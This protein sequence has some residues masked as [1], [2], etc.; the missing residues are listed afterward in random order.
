MDKQFVAKIFL[1]FSFL[2]ISAVILMQIEAVIEKRTQYRSIAQKSVATSWSGQQKI[3][4]PILVIPYTTDIV[5]D[6]G[7]KSGQLYFLAEQLKVKSALNTQNKH[8]GVFEFPVY[9]T[10]LDFEGVFSL[11]DVPHDMISD[12]SVRFETPY[13][14]FAVTDMRGINNAPS[15]KLADKTFNFYPR[16]KLRFSPQGIHAPL[17][18]Y[19]GFSFSQ[20]TKF[21]FQ[22][23][24]SL[25]GMNG[26]SVIPLA[27]Q[28]NLNMKS[29]WAHPNF[30]GNFL[31]SDHKIDK[32]KFTANWQVS[33]FSSNIYQYL[34]EC[35]YGSCSNLLNTRIDV[36]LNTPVDI[37]RQSIRSIKYGLMF[38]GITLLCFLLFE[39]VKKWQ[40]HAMQY[41]LLSM[42]ISVF[43]LLLVALSEHMSFVWAYISASGACILLLMGYLVSILK[44]FRLAGLFGS[45]IALLYGFMFAVLSSEDSALLLGSLL[46]FVLLAIVMI[47]TR[48]TN[49]YELAEKSKLN[50]K[51]KDISQENLK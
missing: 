25:R 8:K 44:S 13:V 40:I 31:P 49:W 14:S 3:T 23:N 17:D 32:K 6:K 22:F 42:P 15:L 5:S 30:G 9:T 47:L 28:F 24:L 21:P 51:S 2:V 34:E 7:L 41:L 46:I 33:E 38:V 27:R 35:E 45:V 10:D 37:Y 18:A 36:Q 11:E 16:S 20:D 4:G 39:V 48:H 26:L 19:N 29:N 1:L 43:F 12:P 50:S